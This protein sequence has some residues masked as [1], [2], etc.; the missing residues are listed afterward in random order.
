VEHGQEVLDERL[1]G[2]FAAGFF[3][4]SNDH[5]PLESQL[6]LAT[7]R[8]NQ[9]GGESQSDLDR[10]D[11]AP[12]RG[13]WLTGHDAVSRSWRARLSDFWASAPAR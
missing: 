12:A 1:D 10:L 13:E 8:Q 6:E 2:P 9:Q 7:R 5:L 11:I 4:I 3:S